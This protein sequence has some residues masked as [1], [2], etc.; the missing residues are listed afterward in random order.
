MHIKVHT[1]ASA[2]I[3]IVHRQGVG[4]LRHVRV[5]Y[6]WVQDKVQ[7]GEV[8][9]Q[10]VWGKENPADLL[11]KHLPAGEVQKHLEALCIITSDDRA[12]SAPRLAIA[13]EQR[14]NDHDDGD[15]NND[16]DYWQKAEGEMKRVHKKPRRTLFTPLRVAEA[17]PARSLTPARITE[18]HF[19]DTGEKFS[20]TDTWT[21]R[22]RAH[23]SMGRQWCGSTRFLLRSEAGCDE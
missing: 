9:V 17:P 20:V 18:G 10:K 12:K 13:A 22:A 2:A 14:R 4:R 16:N 21:S 11:T 3:G 15:D 7:S 5:Q 6:L 23:R 19:M 8:D 1:D